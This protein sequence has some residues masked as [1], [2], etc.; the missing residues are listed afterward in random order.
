LPFLAFFF[1]IQRKMFRN[2]GQAAG[3]IAIAIDLEEPSPPREAVMAPP[4]E[5]AKR[6]KLRITPHGVDAA[7]WRSKEIWRLT[8]GWILPDLLPNSDPGS[9]EDLPW[10]ISEWRV[11]LGLQG[12]PRPPDALPS[13]V[14][15]AGRLKRE[16][17]SFM[18]RVHKALLQTETKRKSRLLNGCL[19]DG[20]KSLRRAA[21]LLGMEVSAQ[22]TGRMAI[23]QP[24]IFLQKQ[25]PHS[26]PLPTE[27]HHL[28]CF[29][30]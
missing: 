18:D 25:E 5:S 12:K 6:F 8:A 14:E 10:P 15:E 21:V 11:G 26:P 24:P 9:S 16:A 28:L 30:F 22:P 1:W 2:L 3:G 20:Q 4:R 13:L 29:F 19:R 7:L 27:D 17:E 23:R